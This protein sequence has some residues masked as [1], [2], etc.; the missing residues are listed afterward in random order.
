MIDS[1]E[2]GSSG[3][4]CSVVG[5]GTGGPSRVGLS[6]GAA[7]AQAIGVV[8]AAIDAGVNFIDTAEAYGT[9]GV[10]ARA[11]AGIRRDH[12]VLSTKISHWEELD[13]RGIERAVDQR[14]RALGTDYLDICHLHA[15]TPE[16]YDEVIAR[17]YPGLLRAREA[18]KVRLL[19]I[20]ERFNHDPGHGMLMQA[21]AGDLWDVVM[22]GFNLLNQSARERV[23]ALTRRRGVAVLAMFAVRRALSSP[24]RLREVVGRL[25]DSGRVSEHSLRAAGGSREEPLAFVT[26]GT[27]APA[28]IVEAAYRFVRHEPGIDVTLSGTGSVEHLHQNIAAVH[29]PPLDDELHQ[30]LIDLFADV[31][32]VTAQ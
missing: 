4:R 25:I 3:I 10:V 24:Q 12:L 13:A 32:N 22:V 5:L 19:G 26:A 27:T 21:L 18:G 17:C 2:L 9:E 7:E 30:R 23:L 16:L 1:V 28:T 31:D 6:S 8:R 15:V 11:I 29:L 20:T 14:L